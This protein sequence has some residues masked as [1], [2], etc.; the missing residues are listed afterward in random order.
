[1]SILGDTQNPAGQSPRQ[2]ALADP[3]LRRGLD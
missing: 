1:V 3:A 2:P